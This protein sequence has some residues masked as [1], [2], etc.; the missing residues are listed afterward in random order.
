MELI[1]AFIAGI[2]LCF[3]LAEDETPEERARREVKFRGK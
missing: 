1:I 2:A 3:W